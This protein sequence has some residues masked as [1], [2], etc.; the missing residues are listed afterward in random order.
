MSI[1]LD[2]LAKMAGLSTSTVSRALSGRR[3]VTPQ[4]ADRVKALARRHGYVIHGPARALRRGRKEAYAVLWTADRPYSSE[5]DNLI[6]AGAQSWIDE[7]AP[8]HLVFSRAKEPSGEMPLAV[9]HRWVDGVILCAVGIAEVDPAFMDCVVPVVVANLRTTTLPS[10][11]YHQE[12][13]AADVVDHLY[14]LGHH[15]IAYVGT[16]ARA[17]EN[18]APSTRQRL[19]GYREACV[20]RG[21]QPSG[22]AYIDRLD[23]YLDSL[24]RCGDPPTALVCY[25]D[26]VSL[27][28]FNY[29]Y[30]QGIRVPDQVSIIGFDDSSRCQCCPVPLSTMRIPFFDAGYRL[31]QMLEER[32]ENPALPPEH[33]V[34][35]AG[36]VVRE[37]TAPPPG[38]A[39]HVRRP[40]LREPL[41]PANVSAM[42]A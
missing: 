12:K 22:T 31:A 42:E 17:K 33:V 16:A 39:S 10:V 30:R 3:R 19:E 28:A 36:L 9:R 27:R 8:R 29:F 2:D 1:T 5:W 23:G 21:I 11:S 7:H 14:R 18:Q 6:T 41:N 13:A 25:S 32:I 26:A 24:W 4:I 37:S 34:L 20:R 15:R 35:D 38:T 40:S